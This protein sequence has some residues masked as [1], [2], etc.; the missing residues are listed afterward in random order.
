MQTA[1]LTSTSRAPRFTL[2]RQAALTACEWSE[3]LGPEPTMLKRTKRFNERDLV[4]WRGYEYG[5]LA[6]YVYKY[7]AHKDAAIPKDCGDW[8][9]M[10]TADLL[11]IGVKADLLKDPSDI[12]SF[13]AVV[14][15]RDEEIVVSFRG[16][17]GSKV[18]PSQ[19]WKS[20]LGE[21]FG[22]ET[23]EHTMAMALA[24]AIKKGL[25]M[26]GSKCTLTFTGHSLGGGLASAAAVV[27][28]LRAYTMDSAPVHAITM[29]RYFNSEKTR[30][31]RIDVENLI[32]NAD[33]FALHHKPDF[34][35]ALNG[36]ASRKAI[37]K[38]FG[39][40]A[41]KAFNDSYKP[42]GVLG[43]STIQRLKKGHKMGFLLSAMQ[44]ETDQRE[45]DG[46][47]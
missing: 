29:L 34:V 32:K 8:K 24:L 12:H 25:S 4:R 44:A 15:K 33:V 10:S 41:T 27:T 28:G 21:N 36:L 45:T 43:D 23:K 26:S 9:V 46:K 39:F 40:E 16:S 42:G 6:H 1:Q 17:V 22:F 38:A 47:R 3:A 13:A 11:A 30:C 18:P 35:S 37:G 19:N 2:T 5:Q 20:N 7:Y 14:L 31:T